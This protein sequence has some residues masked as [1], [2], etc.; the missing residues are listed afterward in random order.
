MNRAI[1]L[2]ALKPVIDSVFEFAE[3]RAAFQKMEAASHFGKI[4]IRF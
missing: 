2:N 1:S 4:V 3:A